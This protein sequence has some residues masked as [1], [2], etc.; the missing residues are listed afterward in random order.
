LAENNLTG[1]ATV[2]WQ[3]TRGAAARKHAFP[4]PLPPLTIY[5]LA[6]P[7]DESRLRQQ[8][9]RGIAAITVSDNRWARCDIKTT[10]LTA[11]V[12]ANQQ[13]VENGADEAIFIRDGALLEGS[14]TNIMAV[15]DGELRTA[16]L[17]NH[18]LPGVTRKAALELC[19]ALAI[20]VREMPVCQNEIPRLGE[21]MILS[22]S[23][24]VTPVVRLDGQPVADGRPG[25]VTRRLGQALRDEITRHCG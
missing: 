9:E 8:Q 2:Y 10:A 5:G 18:I 6:R 20:P 25:P 11:N 7:L 16:P 12:M 15:V 1:A 21:L 23:V 13:A 19:Q 17:S 4:E 24:E 14:H 22:T 3:I